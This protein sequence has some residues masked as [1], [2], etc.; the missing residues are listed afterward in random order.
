MKKEKDNKGGLKFLA[1]T[2]IFLIVSVSF[3]VA[4]V[5]QQSGLVSGQESLTGV[6]TAGQPKNSKSTNAP[7]AAP[8]ATATAANVPSYTV[9]PIKMPS[10]IQTPIKVGGTNLQFKGGDLNNLNIIDPKGTTLGALA[11]AT[12]LANGNTLGTF[13]DSTTKEWTP[14]EWA[15][16]QSELAKNGV[17]TQQEYSKNLLGAK[18]P[19]IAGH[20]VDGVQWAV[21]LGGVGAAVAA[22]AGQSEQNVKAIGLSLGAG[23][24]AARATYGLLRENTAMSGTA[25]TL[26]SAGVGLGV[27]FLVFA[28]LYKK[29]NKKIVKFECQ[30]W[31]PPIGGARCEECNKD[32]F[33]PCSEYRC[34]ALGQACQ[35]LNK[36][37]ANE[38]CAWVNPRDTT[39]PTITPWK[40]ALKPSDLIYAPDK[41]IR[42]PAL[43]VKILKSGGCL[44]AF[45]PLEF[46]IIT[47]EPAQCKIDYVH[48]AN[49]SNMQFDFGDTN[50]YIYNHT[51]KLKL[52]GPES[53]D[54]SSAPVL[55]NDGTYSLYVRCQDANGNHN[56][57]EFSFNFCVDPAPDT[58]PPVID[59]TSLA[60]GSYV[61]F[62]ASNVPIEVYVNEP[63]ECKWSRQNKAYSDMENNMGCDTASYEINS[64]LLYTCTG[65]LTGIKNREDNKFY[66]RCK[67][68]PNSAENE[69]NVNVQSYELTL[70]GTQPLNI[71]K[72]SPNET[73][74]GS[75]DTV[76]VDLQLE[77]DDGAEEG[78]AFCYYSTTGESGSYIEMFETNNFQHK[79]TLDLTSGNYKFYFRCV[80]AGGNSAQNS[81][82]F[83][84]FVDKSPPS[85]TRVYREGTDS[86]KVVTNE[87]AECVYSLNSCNFIFADGLK[88]LYS[89]P[90]IK[91][92]SYAEWKPGVTYNIKCRDTYGNEPSPNE[93]SVIASASQLQS[94]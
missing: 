25:K 77:T 22:F 61:G 35:L 18:I 52:P 89:N 19:G 47:N 86:I 80:D 85:V 5:I 46:G 73:Q 82:T 93:C 8:A 92:S 78:K 91:T 84:V 66:F 70:K 50:L 83:N 17:N 63:A 20:L 87:D 7:S 41:T 56:V 28:L 9:K 23:V 74:R 76:P 3:A 94:V 45:T 1:S 72:V 42:P 4:F 36:G 24:F 12:T 32:K 90:S 16:I 14:Q 79:Q 34:K 58:T 6:G 40:E 39:S 29:E 64:N 30:P 33:R 75:T 81:T 13:K 2:Q 38:N 11:G 88:L 60:S 71:I 21:I 59:S 44:Q 67:D 48:T 69:R 62:N 65:N 53:V 43:G 15:T 57:D 55:K 54:S 26:I 68:Q 51:Q 31:E 49:Y 27:A 10:T 37:S